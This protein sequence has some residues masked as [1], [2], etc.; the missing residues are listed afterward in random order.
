MFPLKRQF[1]EMSKRH[2]GV[3]PPDGAPPPDGAGRAD[4]DLYE[5]ADLPSSRWSAPSR[6]AF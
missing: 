2:A 3:L 1:H 4:L 5:R 6:E